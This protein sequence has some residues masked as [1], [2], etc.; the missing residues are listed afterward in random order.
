MNYSQSLWGEALR[1]EANDTQ[2]HTSFYWRL[3]DRNIWTV[4]KQRRD[5][6]RVLTAC[7]LV[8]PPLNCSRGYETFERW[9]V[10]VDFL[11]NGCSLYFSKPH[12][13]MYKMILYIYIL[14]YWYDYGFKTF[15]GP[16]S[17][18]R[19]VN[20]SVLTYVKMKKQQWPV[21]M[22][23]FICSTT[24]LMWF[25]K[26]YRSLSN[27]CR[28][29]YLV[30]KLQSPHAHF[31]QHWSPFATMKILTDLNCW[32]VGWRRVLSTCTE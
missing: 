13:F 6:A 28:Y 31:H 12:N 3:P 23:T 1:W 5:E 19:M 8:F 24:I 25:R 18:A 11:S 26:W 29:G 17:H 27:L 16:F 15:S 20:E 14:F 9:P 7:C 22:L 32:M 30:S 2:F 4:L 21:T 10:A